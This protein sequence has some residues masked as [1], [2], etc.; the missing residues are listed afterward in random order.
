MLCIL[1]EDKSDSVGQFLCIAPEAS[2]SFKVAKS[3]EFE[4]DS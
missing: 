3:C 2:C 1:Q 4:R